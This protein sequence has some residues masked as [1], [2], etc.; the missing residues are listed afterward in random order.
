VGT[1]LEADYDAYVKARELVASLVHG[2]PDGEA[3]SAY[4][5]ALLELDD[6]NGDTNVP[7]VDGATD[8]ERDALH[9]AA[10]NAVE[11]LAAHG[12]DRLTTQLIVT[13][14]DAGWNAER[15]TEPRKSRT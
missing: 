7:L 9:A 1:V 13:S 8:L 14:L 3:F 2:A 4:N 12:A 15:Q 11:A 10:A 6:L 5:E